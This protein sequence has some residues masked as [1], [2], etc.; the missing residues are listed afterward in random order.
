M[1]HNADMDDDDDAMVIAM[2]DLKSS[3]IPRLLLQAVLKQKSRYKPRHARA[4]SKDVDPDDDGDID[5]GA[6]ESDKL[7]SL[8]EE[9]RGKP[10]PVPASESDFSEGVV[11]QTIK[12]IRPV[13]KRGTPKSV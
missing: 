13:G 11:R 7:V 10:A 4:A 1:P 6:S 8:T 9:K 3:A 5:I 12:K 2:S